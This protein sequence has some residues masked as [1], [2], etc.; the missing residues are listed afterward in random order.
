MEHICSLF[1]GGNETI[2]V[3]VDGCIV[4][5]IA[6]GVNPNNNP[7]SNDGSF[8]GGNFTLTDVTEEP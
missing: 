6:D 3:G 4:N 2:P 7:G 1:H 8:G 5:P